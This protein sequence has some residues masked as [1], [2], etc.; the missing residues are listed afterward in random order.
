MND[1]PRVLIID[2][3]ENITFLVAS[4]LELVGMRATAVT[5]R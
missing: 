3:E 5:T 4:A 2:N 1:R